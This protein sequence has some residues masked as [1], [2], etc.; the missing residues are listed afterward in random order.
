MCESLKGNMA[1]SFGRRLRLTG[2]IL[3]LSLFYIVT[4][5]TILWKC[6][7]RKFLNQSGRADGSLLDNLD[8]RRDD[9]YSRFPNIRAPRIVPEPVIR[10]GDARPRSAD[11]RPRSAGRASAAARADDAARRSSWEA[12][13][14]HMSERV[15][16]LLLGLHSRIA[17]LETAAS[18]EKTEVHQAR[19]RRPKLG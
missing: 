7:Q 13:Q 11:M 3:F 2:R 19:A 15:Q 18:S 4:M 10:G 6:R 8:A 5:L 17:A 9:E 1:Q 16:E 14:V 12:Q